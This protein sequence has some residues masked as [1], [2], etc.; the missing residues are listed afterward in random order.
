MTEPTTKSHK[1]AQEFAAALVAIG[2][3][4]MADW[5][6]HDVA[7]ALDKMKGRVAVDPLV[8]MFRTLPLNG[9]AGCDKLTDDEWLTVANA[10]RD[11]LAKIG[12]KAVFEGE[13][14]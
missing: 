5:E 2:C 7:L 6:I 9:D 1:A 14:A 3:Y 12:G 8:Q 10:A 4:T 13:G 11:A